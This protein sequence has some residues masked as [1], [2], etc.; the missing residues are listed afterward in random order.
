MKF[1]SV[2]LAALLLLIIVPAAS[3]ADFGVRA[4]RYNDSGEKF[5]GAEVLLDV[6]RANLNPN[7]EYLLADDVTAGSVN[8][9]LTF[10]ITTIGS[11]TPYLGVGAGLAYVED[12]FDNSSTEVLGNAIAG[13]TFNLDFLK[14]Y[15]Q[16][17][18]MRSFDDDN[19]SGDDGD[20]AF[21]IGLRF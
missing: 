18:Y 16:I 2:S 5:V 6:G 8:L 10:D 3:A 19:G 7:I 20:L 14:P 11:V 21:T 1:R 17:K 4:G 13:L 12:D 9:D 15:A